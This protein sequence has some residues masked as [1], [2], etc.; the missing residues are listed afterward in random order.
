MSLENHLK[1]YSSLA[2]HRVRYLLIGGAAVI[3]YGIPRNTLDIDIVIE[4]SLK[5]AEKLLQ[6]LK[7]AGLGTARLTTAKKIIENELSV[8]HD[9]I[10]LDILTKPKGLDFKSAWQRKVIKKINGVPVKLASI[11]DIIK[12]KRSIGRPID[13]KDIKILLKINK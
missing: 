13:K 12:S 4:P 1:L 11:K 7:D 6:A 3:I 2:K 9:I 8:F 5:N 10:R